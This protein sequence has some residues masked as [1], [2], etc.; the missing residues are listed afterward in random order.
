M[1]LRLAY[2]VD[3][4]D[5][6]LLAPRPTGHRISRTAPLHPSVDILAEKERWRLLDDHS[7]GRIAFMAD[8]VT[9]RTSCR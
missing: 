3:L 4:P 1:L 5:F 9:R 6:S 7:V 8:R 2:A